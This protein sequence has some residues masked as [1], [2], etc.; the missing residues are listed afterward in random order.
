MAR[1]GLTAERVTEAAADLAD[2][3]GFENVTVSAVA[4]SF[5]V[6][7][8]S[9]YSHVK[10]LQDLRERVTLLAA[11]EVADRIAAAVAGR[12]GK[13]AMTAFA[14]AYRAY[15]LAHP[16]RYAAYQTPLDPAVAARSAAYVRNVELTYAML[17]A[18]DLDEP[19]LTDAGRLLRST[20]H[21]YVTLE[22]NGGFS[23]SREVR[24]SWDSALDGLHFLLQHWPGRPSD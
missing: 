20:F 17:R 14:N 11:G 4:R 16:G 15:A 13:E 21:G 3:I 6:R 19:H 7:D 18:Y 23:H 10:N 5:G 1:A 12:S 8:A 9:L 2:A 24:A 22:L